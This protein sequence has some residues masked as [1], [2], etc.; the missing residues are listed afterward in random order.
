MP[1]LMTLGV[2]AFNAGCAHSTGGTGAP[3]P[4]QGATAQQLSAQA[5]QAYESLAFDA[6]AEGFKASAEVETDAA[7]RAES[8]YRSAGCASLAGQLDA[9]VSLPQRALTATQE[10][11]SQP[12]MDLAPVVDAVSLPTTTD[13][14][15]SV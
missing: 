2:V 5:N 4:R 7:E 11:A 3:E 14:N 8:F 6:C 1:W 10:A 12:V 13:R 15:K 9:A